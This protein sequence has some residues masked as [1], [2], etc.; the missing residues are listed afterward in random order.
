MNRFST[1]LLALAL[2][3]L[4][5]AAP[6][7]DASRLGTE[8]TPSGAERAASKDGTIPAWSGNETQ[9]TGWTWGTYRGAGFK[10]QRDKPVLTID[11]SKSDRR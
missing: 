8:L 7:A 5:P 2:G 9:H 1:P 4:A 3:T 10:H 6:A 11:A